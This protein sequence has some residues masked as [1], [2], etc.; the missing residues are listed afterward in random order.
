VDDCGEAAYLTALSPVL[1]DW[2]DSIHVWLGGEFLDSTLAYEDGDDEETYIL[3]LI[4]TLSQWESAINDSLDSTVVDMPPTYEEEDTP[5]SYLSKF[6]PTMDQWHDS[7]VDLRGE[8]FLAEAPVYTP[9][10]TAPVITCPGDTTLECADSSGFSVEFEFSAEDDCDDSPMLSCDY[11]SGDV[12]YIGETVVTCTATDASGNTSQCSFTVT[13]VE[14]EPPVITCPADITTECT[15]DGSAVVEFEVT[16]ESEC[17]TNVVAVCDPPSGSTFPLGETTVNC[18]ATDRFGNTVEC[19]F[20]VYVEDTTPP[21]IESISVSR[22]YLWPPN[23]R[24]HDVSVMVEASDICDSQPMCY[25]IDVTSN[26][27]ING[28]G[29]GNTEPDYMIV[30]E[31]MVKLRAE[32]AGPMEGRVYTIHVRCE[33]SSGNYTDGTVDVMV[34]HDQGVGA[35]D[36]GKGLGLESSR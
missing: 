35:M 26:E 5:G 24:M 15:G 36:G 3:A 11:E 31:T 30:G 17:D 16:V 18:S 33:D 19:S 27:P 6:A 29:D 23:H 12:F 8:D 22:D 1:V 13:V 10:E 34:P 2:R 7:L 28:V 20:K 21:E 32:R 25:V 14:A 9:D 4:P